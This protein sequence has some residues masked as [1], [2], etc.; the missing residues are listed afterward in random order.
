MA[1]ENHDAVIIKEAV[2]TALKGH[3]GSANVSLL[4][5][6]VK[7][8]N[9]QALL[10][11]FFHKLIETIKTCTEGIEKVR[12][13]LARER[14]LKKFHQIRIETLPC[15]WSKAFEDLG[16]PEEKTIIL[17][18]INRLLFNS[19]VL[20]DFTNRYATSTPTKQVVSVSMCMDEENAV[21]YASGYVV[22]A[23]KKKI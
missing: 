16:I 1:Q 9:K 21:R 11:V 7:D 13:Q 19:V 12:I 15:L 18:S 8:A 10:D 6:S 3:A 20:E 17:Q 23:L 2:T 22:R 5:E 4:L 14:A